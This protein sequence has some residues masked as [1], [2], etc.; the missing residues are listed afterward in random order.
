MNALLVATDQKDAPRVRAMIEAAANPDA[1]VDKAHAPLTPPMRGGGDWAVLDGK[2]ALFIAC[3]SADLT[4]AKLLLE[5]GAS[6]ELRVTKSGA[7]A[8]MV[9][10]SASAYLP[11]RGHLRRGDAARLRRR[12]ERCPR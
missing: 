11:A 9:I 3:F 6:T 1:V 10:A 5:A 12:G 4:I 7:T 8:L 2:S